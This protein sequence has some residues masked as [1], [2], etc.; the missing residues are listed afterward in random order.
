V[1]LCGG[2]RWFIYTVQ[3]IVAVYKLHSINCNENILEAR[4]WEGKDALLVR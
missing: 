3:T 4:G 1:S 2:E